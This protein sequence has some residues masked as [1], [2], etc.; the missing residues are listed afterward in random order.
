MIQT[1]LLHWNMNS[2]PTISFLPIIFNFYIQNYSKFWCVN[3][4]FQNCYIDNYYS[5]LCTSH[6]FLLSN[7]SL[8][9]MKNW[10]MRFQPLGREH[11]SHE[12]WVNKFIKVQC[13]HVQVAEEPT[14]L[15][16]IASMLSGEWSDD[17]L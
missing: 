7:L 16:S 11:I 2:L 6:S 3:V 1:C 8:P 15:V 5:R 17:V 14:P 13:R 9:L 10:Q 4:K 12:S